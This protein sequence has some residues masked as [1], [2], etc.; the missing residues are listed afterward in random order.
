MISTTLDN[1][2]VEEEEEEGGEA[3]GDPLYHVKTISCDPET[4]A[5]MKKPDEI[6]ITPAPAASPAGSA[7]KADVDAAL[8]E[9]TAMGY[10]NDGGWL[11]QLLD[12]KNGDVEETLKTMGKMTAATKTPRK[13][14][15]KTE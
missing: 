13:D 15:K 6:N 8:K 7:P 10:S 5:P 12:T 2:M 4:E 14:E 9:M 3:S 11:K 1:L